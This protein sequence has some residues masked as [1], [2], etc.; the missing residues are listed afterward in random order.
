MKTKFYRCT[1]C[2]NVIVK[3]TDSGVTP[4]CCDA[5]MEE[6]VPKVEEVGME[7]HLPVVTRVDDCT[8]KVEIGSEPHPMIPE[9]YIQ[10]I[11][12][13]TKHGGQFIHLS[14]TCKPCTHFCACKDDPIAVYEYCN[15]HGLWK[16]VLSAD[17]KRNMTSCCTT[18][19]N[20]Q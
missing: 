5:E 19:S 15:I 16:T 6:L 7:K 12:L 4:Y 13:E 8:L 10:W 1:V 18:K 11:Y 17:C 20:N 9:H 2:G 14:P 3:L